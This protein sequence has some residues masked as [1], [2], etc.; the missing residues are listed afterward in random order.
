M[1]SESC[2]CELEVGQSLSFISH[3]DDVLLH[4]LRA[5]SRDCRLLVLLHA[6]LQERREVFLGSDM[7]LLH[8]GGKSSAKA[9]FLF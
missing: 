9:I 8:D 2:Y 3:F 7:S 4:F 1:Q 5:I 6:L